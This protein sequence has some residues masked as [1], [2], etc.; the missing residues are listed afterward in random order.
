MTDFQRMT[1]QQGHVCG[2]PALQLGRSIRFSRV[3]VEAVLAGA[4]VAS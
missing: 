2:V 4:R 3:Q 1:D